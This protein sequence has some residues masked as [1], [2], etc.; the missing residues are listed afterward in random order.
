MDLKH[1]DA[2]QIRDFV[3]EVRADVGLDGWNL[4]V[5]RLKRA[6]IVEKVFKVVILQ[7]TMPEKAAVLE[8]REAMLNVAGLGDEA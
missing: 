8:L 3:K 6:L 7:A 4:L 5:P 1:W 2:A